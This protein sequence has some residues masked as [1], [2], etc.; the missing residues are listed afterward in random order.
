MERF[1]RNVA[2]TTVFDNWSH[3]DCAVAQFKWW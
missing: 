1:L 3:F 2:V